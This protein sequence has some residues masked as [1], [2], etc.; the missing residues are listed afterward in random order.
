MSFHSLALRALTRFVANRRP[1]DVVIGG[2]ESPY[3]RRWWVIPRNPRFNIYLHHFLRPDDDRALHDHPWWN[4]SWLLN[5]SYIEVVPLDPANPAGAT[6]SI[7]REAGAMAFRKAEAAHRIMLHP[8]F[9]PAEGASPYRPCWTLFVTGP[10]IRE[11]GFW[12]P[13]GW[14]HWKDFTAFRTKGDSSTV[15][16]GCGEP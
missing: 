6:R 4:V 14:K 12:C 3:M 5:G 9:W 15:G 7:M 8:E 10:N 1:P 16:P 13:K 11:W 2:H